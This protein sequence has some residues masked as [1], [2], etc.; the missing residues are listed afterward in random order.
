MKRTFNALIAATMAATAIL[1]APVAPAHAG[2]QISISVTPQKQEH[3]DAMNLGLGILSAVK[4]NVTQNG[5]NNSAGLGQNGSNNNG[6]ILQDGNDHTG[7]L[8]QNGDNNNHALIQLGEGT[9]GHVGQN[10]N[11]TGATIQFGWK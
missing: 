3:K 5:D 10:G 8:V 7:T 4:G 6:V 1:A 2:G 11:E 9:N